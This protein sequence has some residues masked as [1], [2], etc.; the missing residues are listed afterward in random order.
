MKKV[1]REY[2]ATR[3]FDIDG[4]MGLTA[5]TDQ[6]GRDWYLTFDP[7]GVS[8]WLVPSEARKMGKL[9]IKLSYK[10][11]VKIKT[12]RKIYEAKK[13]EIPQGP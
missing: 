3:T 5:S 4:T 13:L 10:S 1:T 8:Y 11:K 6:E 12:R 7:R 2:R 9:L